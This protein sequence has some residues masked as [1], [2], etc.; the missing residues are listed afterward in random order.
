MNARTID[1]HNQRALAAPFRALL[2]GRGWD[3]IF[4]NPDGTFRVE[5]DGL[6]LPDAYNLREQMSRVPYE[7]DRLLEINDGFLRSASDHAGRQPTR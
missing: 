4:L 7:L 5:Q 1:T 2:R 6:L 3:A